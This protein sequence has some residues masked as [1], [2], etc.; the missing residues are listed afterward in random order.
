[1]DKIIMD[2]VTGI[3]TSM[4]PYPVSEKVDFEYELARCMDEWSPAEILC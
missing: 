1:M 4:K 2:T 3:T